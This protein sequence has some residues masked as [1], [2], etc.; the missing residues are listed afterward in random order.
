M[1]DRG[2]R[3]GGVL[4]H[5]VSVMYSTRRL[6]GVAVNLLFLPLPKFSSS[7]HAVFVLLSC[8][9]LGVC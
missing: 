8:S 3:A 6:L 7:L 5:L 2:F 1:R 4:E 9:I